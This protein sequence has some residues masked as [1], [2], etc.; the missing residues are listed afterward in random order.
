[1]TNDP[2]ASDLPPRQRTLIV[3]LSA[4]V[5]FLTLEL[6]RRRKVKEDD[7]WLWLGVGSLT[8][9]LGTNYPIL[10]RLTHFLGI[11]APASAIFFFGQLFLMVLALQASMRDATV[12]TQIKNLVQELAILKAQTQGVGRSR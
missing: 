5:F 2:E 1:M 10:R 7:S 9:L 3:S 11:A 8:F 12:T 4:A 6:V